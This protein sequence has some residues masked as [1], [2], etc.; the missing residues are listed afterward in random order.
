MY[1]IK[2]ELLERFDEIQKVYMHLE[3]M[4]NGNVRYEEAFS[5][6]I[7]VITCTKAGIVLMLYNAVES[8][9]TKCITRI[10]QELIDSSLTFDDC[11]DAIQKLIVVY[12]ENAKN[13]SNDIHAQVPHIIAFHNYLTGQHTFDLTYDKLSEN[14]TLYSGN[15]DAKAV[16]GVL[17]EYGINADDFENLKVS[18]LQT[19]KK[20]RNQLAHGEKSFQEVGNDITIQR[21][22]QMI[23]KTQDFLNAVIDVVNHY[24]SNQEFKRVST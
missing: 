5:G 24:I 7:H 14:Y 21:L 13:K 22:D 19:I 11:N 20:F 18:E 4:H 6:Q 2:N 16:R 17:T 1:G 15:L 23:K 3:L 10:H 12:Y 9:I 8:T